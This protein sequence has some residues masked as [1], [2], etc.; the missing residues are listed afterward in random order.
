MT[1][2]CPYRIKVAGENK[3]LHCKRLAGHSES[4]PHETWKGLRPQDSEPTEGEWF[5][6]KVSA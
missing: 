6:A 1:P 5:I 4:E 3:W 2:Q